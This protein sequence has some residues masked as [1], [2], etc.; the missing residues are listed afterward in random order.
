MAGSATRLS[1][2]REL[3]AQSRWAE[4]CVEFAAADRTEQL[5]ADDLESYAEAAQILGRGAEA[6]QL[7]RRAFNL[8]IDAGEV[9]QA[10]TSA[11]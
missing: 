2:A 11:F 10:I 6:I 9:D 3:H 5:T 1:Q 4:A 7:L 8:R